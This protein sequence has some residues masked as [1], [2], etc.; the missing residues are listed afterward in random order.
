MKKMAIATVILILPIVTL[1][2]E[3][4]E[5]LTDPLEQVGY[6][7]EEDDVASAESRQRNEIDFYDKNRQQVRER[8]RLEARRAYRA[9]QQQYCCPEG[10][11][12]QQQPNPSGE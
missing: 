3:V 9:Q 8:R 10:E 12:P 4:V 1:V 7:E 11:Y 5:T 2:S 6:V